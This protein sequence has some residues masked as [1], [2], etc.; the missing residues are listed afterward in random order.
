MTFKR[1]RRWAIGWWMLAVIAGASAGLTWALVFDASEH[2]GVDEICK[3]FPSP[4]FQRPI[5]YAV[6]GPGGA[7]LAN[8]GCS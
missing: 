5:E 7:V 1:I 6:V 3:A 8:G 2:H 4:T